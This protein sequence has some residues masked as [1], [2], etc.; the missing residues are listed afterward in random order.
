MQHTSK[1]SQVNAYLD[2]RMSASDKKN[3]EF[4]LSECSETSSI[5]KKKQ[6][7]LDFITELIPN[8]SLSTKS[9]AKL[10]REFSDINES[11]LVEK[12]KTLTKKVYHFFTKP[13]IEF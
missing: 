3:F 9:H 12:P 2:Q 5:L 1:A 11:L 7:H 10:E 8:E 4:L 6:A 13:I